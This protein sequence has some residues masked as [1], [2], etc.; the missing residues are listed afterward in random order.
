VLDV[1][2]W[3]DGGEVTSHAYGSLD[4]DTRTMAMEVLISELESLK[5]PKLS[6]S[7]MVMEKSKKTRWILDSA[8]EGFS[9]L[10]AAPL[11]VRR[12]LPPRYPAFPK[13]GSNEA[14]YEWIL[15]CSSI[16]DLAEEGLSSCYTALQ[17]LFRF[18][19]SC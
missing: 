2:V 8:R 13:G 9:S 5:T 3:L 12:P 4:A 19:N 14:V 18:T 10:P 16:L 6:V 15:N 17:I 7:S 11:E 1:K